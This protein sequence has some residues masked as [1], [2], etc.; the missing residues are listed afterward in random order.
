MKKALINIL[1][2]SLLGILLFGVISCDN[3]FSN[4]VSD[5]ENTETL[6]KI[7]VNDTSLARTLYPSSDASLLSD[8]T[9][10]CTREGFTTK[11]KTAADLDA[12]K[13]LVINFADGE[14]GSWQIQ[15]QASYE[16]SSGTNVQAIAFSDTQSVDVQKNKLNEVSFKLT[17]ENLAVGGLNIKV[18]FSGSADRVVASLKDE[19]KETSIDEKIFTTSDFTTIEDEKSITFTRAIS[20][21]SEALTSGTYYLLFSFYDT[22]LSSETPLNTLPNYVRI[23]KGLTTSAELS[24]SLNE[25]YTITY[26]DNGGTLASGAIKTG[27]YSRKSIVNLPQMEKEG[28]IFAGWYEASDFSG[29][30]VTT[31]EK[32]SSGNKTFYARFV[33]STLYV[34]QSG[35]NEN[36]GMTASTALASVNKAVEKII[37]YGNIAAAY[38]IKISGTITGGVNIASTLTTEMASSLTLEGVTGQSGNDW[39]DVLNGGFTDSNRGTTLAI[40]TAVPVT[41][42]NLKIT[43]GYQGQGNG[44]GVRLGGDSS[45]VMESGEISGN[46][47]NDG[48]QVS[49]GG[50]YITHGGT[51][52]FGATQIAGA[53]FTMTGGS[54]CNN[55]GTGVT[56][57]DGSNPGEFNMYGGTITG[58]SGYGVNIVYSTGPFGKFTMKGDAVVA[59]NNKVELGFPGSTKIY[60]AGELTES[61]PVATVT[62]NGYNENTEIVALAEGVTDTSL[63]SAACAKIEVAPN[64]STPWYLT[65]DGKLT[66]TDPN[67]SNGGNNFYVDT[68]GDDEASGLD[69]EH[70]LKTIMAAIGKMDDSNADYVINVMGNLWTDNFAPDNDPFE[71]TDA[72]NGKA[73]SITLRG[74]ADSGNYNFDGQS[75]GDGTT[76]MKVTTSVPIIL[77]KI[78]VCGGCADETNLGGAIYIGEEST[79]ILGQDTIVNGGGDHGCG[80]AIFVAASD[81]GGVTKAGTLIMKDNA[82][83]NAD[84]YGEVYL[85][86]GATIKV[87]S[88]LTGQSSV[89]D[90]NSGEYIPSSIVAKITPQV[91]AENTPVIALTDDALATLT[92]SDVYEKFAVFEEDTTSWLITNEGKLAKASNGGNGGNENLSINLVAVPGNGSDIQNLLVGK[93]LITQTEYE[94]FMKYHGDVV[95]GSSYKPSETGD[96]KNTTPAYYV[97]FVDA[98]IFCNLL[99]VANNLEP[100]YK[101]GERQNLPGCVADISEWIKDTSLGIS[102]SDDKYCF[103]WD[104]TKPYND[105]PYWQWDSIYD[106]GKLYTDESANGYRL[107]TLDEIAHIAN[108][109]ISHGF[110][111]QSSSGINEWCDAYSQNNCETGIFTA[112]IADSSEEYFENC[113][114]YHKHNAHEAPGDIIIGVEE[115]YCCG[116][117]ENFTR[118]LGFRVVRNAGANGGSNP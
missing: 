102:N 20:D 84:E 56:L 65:S 41:L 24:I 91:Y 81:N 78:T 104:R 54:I 39:V 111:L 85:C 31:I 15:L 96:A 45:L 18:S 82:V 3:I 14:E 49:A 23:V 97:S 36:D 37:S 100:V 90:S 118:N 83:V 109:N 67:G 70:S 66:A 94:H 92:I 88:A 33:S 48:G 29:D 46:T 105:N 27:K 71:I 4:K 60:I 30:P 1:K 117:G 5:T 68:N 106:G 101:I 43:G 47:A 73:K 86:T 116:G 79:V 93:N 32:G 58:N 95:E 75:D 59:A 38:T 50:V 74:N 10:T 112:N 19:T 9:L 8:F 64:N 61:A 16:I 6:L 103:A 44:G 99:S 12:L 7:S 63:L 26:E 25:V 55:T 22:T 110:E 72:I 35:N 107:A 2:S 115:V 98:V 28:Y 51:S 108:W 21:T 62:L 53:K 77:E 17:T 13:A 76:V 34:S 57:Y 113:V 11:T 87:A 114:T 69:A 42:K 52:N 80:S 40:N 89:W